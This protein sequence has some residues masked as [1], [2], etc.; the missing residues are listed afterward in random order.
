[1]NDKLP[2]IISPG[3]LLQG[4]RSYEA[5]RKFLWCVLYTGFQSG[6]WSKSQQSKEDV[7]V[8]SYDWF[9]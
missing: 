2:F 7:T 4:L 5:T 1:L 9:V 6:Y 3:R 8:T